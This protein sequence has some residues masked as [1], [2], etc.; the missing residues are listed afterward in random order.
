MPY[1][2]TKHIDRAHQRQA[3]HYNKGREDT[4]FQVGDMVMRKTHVLSNGPQGISTKLAPKWEG[5]YEIIE[6]RAPIVSILKMETG[7]KK[8]KVHV[9]ELKKYREGQGG[10]GGEET[11]Q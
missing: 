11:N 9:G 4:R 10:K 2:V 5:P 3:G 1:L 8:P 7:C 6:V